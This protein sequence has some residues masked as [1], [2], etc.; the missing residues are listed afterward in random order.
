MS[1]ENNETNLLKSIDDIP[2]LNKDNVHIPN[3]EELLKKLNKMIKDG[4]RMLQIVTDFDH[5][6]TRHTMDNGK[7]VLT[8]FGMF[9]ECPSI[10]QEYKDEEIRLASIYKPI[11]VDPVMSIE[12]KTKHMIDWYQAAHKLLQGMKF[13]KQELM[14]IGYKMVECFRTGVQDLILWSERHQVP[15]L[16]FSAGLGES[17]LAALK[18]ANFLLPHVK[19]ISNFL[20]MDESDTIVGIKG[21][22]IHTYNKNEAAIKDTEYFSLV[23][24]RSNVLLLGDNIGDAGMAQGMDHCHVVLKVGFLGRNARA[25]LHNYLNTFDL[26]LVDEPTMDVPNAILKLVL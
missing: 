11:E 6:L 23:Q 1:S 4:N 18:A 3:K 20:A 2:E 7:S 8:S 25:N 12:E 9:R 13:P 14:D 26:V 16:V 15:V 10:P 5:T 21:E 24:T 19:V 22:V 17:V